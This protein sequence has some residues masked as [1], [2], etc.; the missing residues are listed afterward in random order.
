MFVKESMKKSIGI[1]DQGGD[2]VLKMLTALFPDVLS[3]RDVWKG[4]ECLYDVMDDLE[5]DMPGAVNITATVV[6]RCIEHHILP[7]SYFLDPI[8]CSSGGEVIENAKILLLKHDQSKTRRA[9][10]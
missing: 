3:T 2:L 7:R 1:G 4:F 9:R 10:S 6:C 5:K 8:V